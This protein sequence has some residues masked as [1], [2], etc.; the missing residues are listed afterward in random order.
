MPVRPAIR[1]G[2]GRCR[3]FLHARVSHPVLP[4]LLPQSTP[5]P[6]WRQEG[7]PS[8]PRTSSG[9]DFDEGLGSYQFDWW[10]SC[11]LLGFRT[12]I[13]NEAFAIAAIVDFIASERQGKR[14]LLPRRTAYLE[15]LSV[16]KAHQLR[17]NGGGLCCPEPLLFRFRDYRRR[18]RPSGIRARAAQRLPVR[19]QQTS[20]QP[21]LDVSGN[22]IATDSV[23]P[24]GDLW[25]E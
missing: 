20:H 24:S 19:Q 1:P 4:V 9:L 14:R 11:P 17:R 6:S 16:Q 7:E 15:C 18:I 10:T 2:P 5:G 23:T 3:L 25:R 21:Q 22:A 13:G 8:A 12:G